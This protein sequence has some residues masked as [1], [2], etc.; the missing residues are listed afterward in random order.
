MK[1]KGSC[2]CGRV[3]L[4]VESETYFPY[5]QS[6]CSICRKTQGGGGFGV[7]LGA[8]ASTLTMTVEE[9][10]TVY[11]AR[12]K[13]P[14]ERAWPSRCERNFCTACGS[15]LWPFDPEWPELVHP[16]ASA[17]DSP[18]PTAPERTHLMLDF[19][20]PWGPLVTG[21]KDKTYGR[22]PEESIAEWHEWVLRK[23]GPEAS[24]S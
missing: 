24:L 1:L 15:A 22:Y 11:R 3:S 12:V 21:K 23:R 18:L 14:G 7:N 9:H 19:R 4:T 20:A 6:Y 16:F 10:I 2:H 17:I 8:R 5:Q 13:N